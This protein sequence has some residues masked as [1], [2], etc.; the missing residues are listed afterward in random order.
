MQLDEFLDHRNALRRKQYATNG[1]KRKAYNKA[2]KDAHR[3]QV[4]AAGRE[5]QRRRR[6]NSTVQEQERI[7]ALEWRR[8]NPE[9]AKE[10]YQAWY[11]KHGKTYYKK[12]SHKHRR[13]APEL[14]LWRNGRNSAKRRGIEFSLYPEDIVVPEFCPV[15]GIRLEV[16]D[17]KSWRHR[18]SPSLDRVDNSKGYVSS[19]VR[20]IS[21]RAN[22][23]KNDGTLEEHEAI[24]RYM[25]GAT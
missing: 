1:E 23:V 9:L 6:Q 25:R 3:E 17:G 16:G 22:I 5:Y 7:A 15:L 2:W 13:L 19:N 11:E 21:F 4:R 20:V 18:A 14:Y 12:W 10:R 8:Q 24:V